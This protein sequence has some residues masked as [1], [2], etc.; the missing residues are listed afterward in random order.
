VIAR[1][2][3]LARALRLDVPWQFKAPLLIAIPYYFIASGGLGLGRAAA[4]IGA[5]LATIAGI[6]GFAYLLNDLTDRDEDARSGKPN[7]AAGRAPIV[8]ALWLAGA[9]VLAIG[10]WLV[11]LPFTLAIG[12]LLGLEFALLAAYSLPPVRLKERGGVGAGADALYAH[13]VPAVLA[14]LT[15]GTIADTPRD[16][17]LPFVGI[18]GAWQL[19]SGLRNITLHQ[20]KDHDLDRRA[21]T[22]TWVTAVGAERAERILRR[23]LVPAELA[24]FGVF[25]GLVSQQLPLFLPGLVVAVVY[26][27]ASRWRRSQPFDFRAFLFYYVDDLY[28]EWTPLLML[29][30]L[31]VSHRA[32]WLLF[33]LHLVVFQ[34]NA[35]SRIYRDLRH[36]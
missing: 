17:L 18:L 26:V 2:A 27:T 12:S 10:P 29:I 21:G 25:A 34:K 9:L 19:A 4:V 24:L 11:V 13:A 7:F 20:V 28:V 33:A 1:A 3:A 31:A 15:F 23:V 16:V 5:S 35:V 36:L 32:F 6:A 22:R 14:A 30:D 8:L